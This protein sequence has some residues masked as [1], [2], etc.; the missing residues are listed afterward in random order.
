GYTVAIG[1]DLGII[2]EE[3]TEVPN[4]TPRTTAEARSGEVQ[5]R[6]IKD[7]HTGVYIESQIGAD[8]TWDYLAIDTTS[9][10]NDSRPLRTPGQPEKRRY[11]MCFWD[12]TPT[13]NWTNIVE[14]TFGG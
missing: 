4:A 5:L 8:T 13:N 1:E 10:Y 2:G 12:G 11:R 7:G 9:P 6:F 3:S 14:V